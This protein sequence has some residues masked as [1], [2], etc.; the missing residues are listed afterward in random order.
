MS[1]RHIIEHSVAD[2]V[3][4]TEFASAI[5]WASSLARTLTNAGRRDMAESSKCVR[6]EAQRQ[7]TTVEPVCL[8]K[9]FELA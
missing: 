4:S 3:G 2:K 5:S 6:G 9:F 8:I 7:Q 1:A